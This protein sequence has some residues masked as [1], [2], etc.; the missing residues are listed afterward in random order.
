MNENETPNPDF[1]SEIS[2]LGKKLINIVQITWNSEAGQKVR[3]D[4]KNSLD[5]LSVA[6]RQTAEELK[7]PEA[8]SRL[9]SEAEEFIDQIE[10]RE[11]KSKA[12]EELLDVLQAVNKELERA[13]QHLANQKQRTGP[14]ETE[15]NDG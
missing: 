7:S 10:T 9:R 15:E 6:A 13:I 2:E 14:S 5:E 4:I 8:R 3:E 12:K 11:L 1:P